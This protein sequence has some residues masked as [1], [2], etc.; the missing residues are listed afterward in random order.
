MKTSIA[1]GKT[2]EHQLFVTAFQREKAWKRDAAKNL[3]DSLI[4]G[5]RRRIIGDRFLLKSKA[6]YLKLS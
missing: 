6:T 2:D 4:K 3:I 5:L 1:I